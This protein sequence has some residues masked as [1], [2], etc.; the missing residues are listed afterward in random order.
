MIMSW[1][2]WGYPDFA[3]DQLDVEEIGRLLDPFEAAFVSLKGA[4]TFSINPLHPATRTRTPGATG[5]IAGEREVVAHLRQGDDSVLLLEVVEQ[6]FQV[7]PVMRVEI[8]VDRVAHPG[9]DAQVLGG[10]ASTSR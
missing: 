7:G 3:K 4:E 10:F 1:P 9:Q 2:S 6:R 5:A 8:P